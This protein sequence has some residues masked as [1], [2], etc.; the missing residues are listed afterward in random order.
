MKLASCTT[1]R[2]EA[3]GWPRLGARGTARRVGLGCRGSA[4]ALLGDPPRAAGRGTE[5]I[6]AVARGE[7]LE[8]ELC[9]T[10]PVMGAGEPCEGASVT[11][12]SSEVLPVPFAGSAG[13]R[14]SV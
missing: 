6:G 13:L 8:G 7:A 5:E 10:R 1:H 2:A 3:C 11:V 12:P 9:S 4:C 14:D